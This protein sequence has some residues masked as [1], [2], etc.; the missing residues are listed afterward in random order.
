M[1]WSRDLSPLYF[2]RQGLCRIHY[3]CLL[4][5]F[6]PDQEKEKQNEQGNHNARR[7]PKIRQRTVQNSTIYINST[8]TTALE[9]LVVNQEGQ[10]GSVSLTWVPDKFQSAGLLVQ[11]KTFKINFQNG[12]CWISDQNNFSYFCFTNHLNISYQVS[13]QLF[14]FF[15]FLC[16]RRRTSK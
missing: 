15:F 14:F 16:F 11:E 13:S 1:S 4:Q 9:R 8:R 12:R 5:Y 3:F 10:D 6:R 2:T 7:N